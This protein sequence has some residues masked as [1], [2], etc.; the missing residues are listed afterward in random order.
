MAYGDTVMKC[1]CTALAEREDKTPACP[2]C[3]TIEVDESPPSLA[4]RT[5]TC[6]HGCK[7]QP[8]SWKLPFF[9]HSPE[10]TQDSYYCGC[11][12]WG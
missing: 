6:R 2:S 1:G 11:Y 10:F 9:K 3:G 12:G 4:G 7:P 8:S 5:A